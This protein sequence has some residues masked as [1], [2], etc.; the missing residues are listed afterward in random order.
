MKTSQDRSEREHDARVRHDQHAAVAS[1]ACWTCAQW[2]AVLEQ[3]AV[4]RAMVAAFAQ[5]QET[6]FRS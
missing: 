1:A 5:S 6:F 2:Y 4:A 3:N